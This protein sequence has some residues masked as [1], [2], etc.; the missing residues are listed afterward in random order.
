[1]DRKLA[2]QVQEKYQTNAAYTDVHTAVSPWSRT[3][4]DARV[5]GAGTFAATFFPYGELLLHDQEVYKHHCWSEGHHQW[6]YAGL[7]TGNYGLTYSSLRMWEYPYLPH[8]E[9]LKIHPLSVDIGIPWT[10]H[11]FREKEGWNEPENIV[12][13]IDQFLAATIAF[14]RMAWLVEEEYGM[15][16]ACRSYYMM[17][18]LQS[19]YV[20]EKPLE[21]LYGSDS[22]LI[23]SSEAF[24]NGDWRH[25]KLFVHY[26]GDLKVWVNG[27]PA[28]PWQVEVDGDVHILPPYG[29]LAVQGHDFFESSELLDGSRCDRVSSSSYVFLDGRGMTRDFSGVRTAGSLAVKPLEENGLLLIAVEGVDQ[30]RLTEPDSAGGAAEDVRN[31]IAQ[32]AAAEE[33][34][35]EAFNVDGLSLGSAEVSRDRGGWT[36]YSVPEALR[37]ELR[38]GD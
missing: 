18:Q 7:T 25:S 15:R 30:I 14:G 31:L 5:P 3:D 8:F 6:L 34:N 27:N 4:Y 10:R 35:V 24:L 36:I 32:A 20:M 13:S 22:G 33:L 1:M 21:I 23:N 28:Q 17:Q 16:Q 37:Y 29:W 26:P 2:P 38:I 9:L 11:F 19:R 12:A